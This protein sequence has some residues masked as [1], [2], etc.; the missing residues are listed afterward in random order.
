MKKILAFL[1]SIALC[2]SF[3]LF[4]ISCSKNNNGN[5]SFKGSVLEDSSENSSQ[6]SNLVDSS[7][8]ED[9][10]EM[11]D[12]SSK[13]SEIS[14]KT[15]D[16]SSK[17]SEIS[18]E[19]SSSLEQSSSKSQNAENLK[20]IN[21]VIKAISSLPDN[22]SLIDKTA[23][24]SARNLYDLLENDLK[25]L[26]TNYSKLLNCENQ[27]SQ[28]LTNYIVTIYTN[29]GVVSG[30]KDNGNGTFSLVL[31][32]ENQNVTPATKE[33]VIFD[34]YYLNADFS[35]EKV[36]F[37]TGAT[38]LYAK[39]RNKT[40]SEGVQ[41]NYELN[42]GYI[43]NLFDINSKFNIKHVNKSAFA[44]NGTEVFIYNSQM[45][46]SDT[47]NSYTYFLKIKISELSRGFYRINEIINS[48]TALDSAHK[49]DGTYIFV[50]SAYSWAYDIIKNWEIGKILYLSKELPTYQSST[51]NDD[52]F[53]GLLCIPL[54]SGMVTYYSKPQELPTPFKQGATFEGFYDNASFEGN[55]ITEINGEINLYAKWSQ[56][57]SPLSRVSDVANTNT[58]D[59][60]IYSS[61]NGSISFTSSNPSLYVISN[62]QGRVNAINQTHKKQTVT[63]TA[64]V[65]SNG[66][67]QNYSK[68]ITV[69][70]IDFYNI[71]ATPVAT[72][73]SIG[74]F[75]S[76]MRYN[77]RYKA[78]GTYF[79]DSTKKALDII[80]YSFIYLDS[81]ANVSLD[82]RYLQEVRKL[83][84]NKVRIV[85]SVSGVSASSSADFRTICSN[86]DLL[87]KF[88]NNL[89]DL[90]EAN[91][92]D[93]LDIDWEAV[94]TTNR[95]YADL[96]NK[97]M[98]ALREEMSSRQQAGGSPYLLSCAV[99]ASSWGLGAERFDFKTLNNYVDYVNLMSYDLHNTGLTSH[100]SPMYS[101]SINGLYK[102]GCDWG[103]NKLVELGLSQNKVIIGSAGYGKAY[104]IT[105][106]L[107]GG[108]NSELGVS[109]TLTAISGYEGS[110]ASGTVYGNVIKQLINSGRYV[111]KIEYNSNNQIVGS[112]LYSA[113]DNIYVTYDSE[114]VV[115]AKYNYAKQK[116]AGIM[117]WCYSE[118]TSDSV[119]NAISSLI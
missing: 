82:T 102:F 19:N 74:S 112:Y 30:A 61:D 22:V 37:V 51:N 17:P 29:G 55:K 93:G 75:S 23:V 87:K 107:N 41:V 86:D 94:D 24:E 40:F 57:I 65:N 16:D 66:K 98:K 92:L 80:Y 91:N 3:S 58:I 76:Y 78:N 111:K 50:H 95:P 119:I 71:S 110:F 21:N 97:L 26:V 59:T 1:F 27:I 42:G 109:G 113:Q 60:L 38:T 69:N 81:Q 48:G 85:A 90:V 25:N 5:S 12:N 15:N 46:S 106:S 13:T 117:C 4:T 96:M 79:S 100:L 43:P 20:K 84:E 62:G 77:D 118:D 39:F 116:G 108:N 73:F 72:Y 64:S 70:P 47:A 36:S 18:S 45:L 103:L 54:T 101:T 44:F 8:S 89:M 104:R 35:G 105:G 9:S 31:S 88:V 83:R 34:G 11:N 14:S 32:G 49:N 99:P 56:S 7:S 63:I 114:E 33:G 10:S 67:T 28:L 52:N 6:S 115:K 53:D 2:L 68:I